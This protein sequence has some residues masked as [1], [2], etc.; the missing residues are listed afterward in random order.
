[1]VLIANYFTQLYKATSAEGLFIEGSYKKPVRATIQNDKTMQD[2][3]RMRKDCPL[4]M[5]LLFPEDHKTPDNILC[6]FHN[7]RSLNLHFPDVSSSVSFTSS[8]VIMLAET[9][10]LP[11]DVFA[12]DEY[13]TIHRTDCP[14]AK[15]K[16]FGTIMFIKNSLAII[17]T[18][19]SSLK[20][21]LSQLT[22]ILQLLD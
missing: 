12:I 20:N 16:A 14:S 1:M 6:I 18:L 21:R 22:Q 19:I 7:V 17:K 13:S 8:D 9:W 4:L 2:M 10:S 15:R 11:S 3:E 5:T